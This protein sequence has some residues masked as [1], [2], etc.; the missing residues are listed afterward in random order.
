M[1]EKFDFSIASRESYER[2]RT[3]LNKFI[4]SKIFLIEVIEYQC[5]KI[6]NINK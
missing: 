5:L 4:I 3:T 6:V 1:N 2:T